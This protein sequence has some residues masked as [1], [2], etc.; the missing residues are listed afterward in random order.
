MIGSLQEPQTYGS[1]TI[2]GVV[3]QDTV[4]LSELKIPKKGPV[5]PTALDECVQN[6]QFIAITQSKGLNAGIQ[7]ILG[8]GPFNQKSPSLFQELVMQGT[9]R[10]P[11]ISFSL[12]SNFTNTRNYTQESYM[13]LG[14]INPD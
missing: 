5:N 6:F 4:C 10:D 2:T 9:I 11:V 1:A 14:G 13:L 8:L 3:Y 12:G 7:G